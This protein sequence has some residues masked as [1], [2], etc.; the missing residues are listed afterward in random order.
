MK[1]VKFILHMKIQQQLQHKNMKRPKWCSGKYIPQC[2][3]LSFN[4][5]ITKGYCKNCQYYKE[6]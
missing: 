5:E 6:K 4:L 2:Y 3:N 1:H